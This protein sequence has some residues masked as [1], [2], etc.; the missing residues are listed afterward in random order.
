MFL[1][2]RV[3]KL[4]V[5]VGVDDS[6]QWVQRAERIPQGEDSIQRIDGVSLMYFEIHAEIA[7]VCIGKQV[8]ADGRMIQGGI[9]DGLVVLVGSGDVD[10]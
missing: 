3:D 2:Q 6:H 1:Y 4:V 5:Q 8:R 9:E 10:F 7:S